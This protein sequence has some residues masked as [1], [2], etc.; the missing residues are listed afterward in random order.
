MWA[1]FGRL[2]SLGTKMRQLQQIAC[3]RAVRS[4]R[5]CSRCVVVRSAFSETLAFLF[6]WVYNISVAL[7]V[8]LCICSIRVILNW[9]HCYRM[10]SKGPKIGRFTQDCCCADAGMGRAR[11][12]SPAKTRPRRDVTKT[13]KYVL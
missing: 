2:T 11:L 5:L 9:S 13:L 7:Y 8:T 10:N 3:S 12:V 6:H 4:S 1:L